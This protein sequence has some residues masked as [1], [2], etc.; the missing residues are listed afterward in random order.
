MG[1][2]GRGRNSWSCWGRGRCGGLGGCRIGR[3][4]R[5]RSCWGGEME[6]LL[7]LEFCETMG[8][9]EKVV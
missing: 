8:V 9:F 7:L 5:G 2:G 4:R 3:E 1:G 6:E